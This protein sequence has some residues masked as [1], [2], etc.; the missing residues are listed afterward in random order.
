MLGG[1]QQFLEFKKLFDG[2]FVID[3]SFAPSKFK[4]KAVFKY[5]MDAF[6]EECE[7]KFSLFKDIECN[8]PNGRRRVNEM[9][10]E[11]SDG[12]I[13]FS[14]KNDKLKHYRMKGTP[15][16]YYHGILKKEG[17]LDDI[18]EGCQQGQ[19]RGLKRGRQDDGS[20]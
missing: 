18:L 7:G 3:K 14:G 12:A 16:S 4:E 13:K 5:D 15:M 2:Y 6:L 10:G 20:A 19:E 11:F 8:T 1:V 17:T 9:L